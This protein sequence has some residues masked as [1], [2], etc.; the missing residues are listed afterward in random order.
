MTEEPRRWV[1]RVIVL[2]IV[3]PA[4]LAA[5]VTLIRALT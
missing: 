4:L 2:L 3:G 5:V 1:G